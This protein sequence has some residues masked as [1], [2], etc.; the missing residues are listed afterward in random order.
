MSSVRSN[1]AD[2]HIGP[3]DA[4][5]KRMLSALGEDDLNAFISKVVPQNIALTEK[6]ASALPSA[7]QKCLQFQNFENLLMKTR[8]L[9]L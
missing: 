2:R 5:T 4:Q 7:F 9:S 8:L 6:I 3:D 1:F